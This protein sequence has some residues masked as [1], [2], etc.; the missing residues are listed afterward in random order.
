MLST[1]PGTISGGPV[2]ARAAAS[3]AVAALLAG[4]LAGCNFVTPQ[5]T[6]DQYAPTDGVNATIGDLALRNVLA[7]TEDGSDV[8]LVLVAAN[9]SGDDIDLTI[10]ADG[11]DAELVVEPGQS[12]IGDDE[13][14]VLAGVD[15]TVGS[16][17][18]IYFQYGD[19]PGKRV[20]VPVLDGT[21]SEYADLVPT[22]EPTDE[23][24]ADPTETPLP[25]EP[26]ET[27]DGTGDVE[28]GAEG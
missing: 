6:L 22:A 3:V 25:G 18:D 8:N 13:Q 2:R 17:V 27:T 19:E 12:T 1:L 14:L 28:D 24:T 26:G 11:A 7:I 9:T 15:V 16:L 10:Q 4:G 20:R 23:A 21:L 5:A